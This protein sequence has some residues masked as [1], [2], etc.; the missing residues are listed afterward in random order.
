MSLV[1]EGVSRKVGAETHIYPMDLAL[2]PGSL[3]VILGPTLAGKTSLM[4]LMAANWPNTTA[5]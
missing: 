4:R 5:L 1:F 3:N 2:E